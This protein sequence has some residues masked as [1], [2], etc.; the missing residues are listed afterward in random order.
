MFSNPQ[1]VTL[2]PFFQV[3]ELGGVPMIVRYTEMSNTIPD[4]KVTA[5]FLVSVCLFF[6]PFSFGLMGLG[7][8][9]LTSV[10]FTPISSGLFCICLKS[11]EN[12]CN[13]RTYL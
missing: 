4:Q 2:I 9:G 1:L 8:S 12:M 11:A 3:N 10:L 13:D 5:T 7:Y 6:L